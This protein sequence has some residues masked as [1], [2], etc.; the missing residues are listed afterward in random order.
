MER[1]VS[2]AVGSKNV[3][4][5]PVLPE[6]KISRKPLAYWRNKENID[7][8]LLKLQRKYNLNTQED[9]NAISQKHILLNGGRSLLKQ[10]SIYELKCMA[11]P[12]GKLIFNNQLPTGYW[13]NQENI[14]QFLE[15]IKKKYN[16]NTPEDWNSITT[17]HIKSNGGGTL[18]SKYSIYKL[19]CLACPEGKSIF[20]NPKHESGYWEN[21]E[22]IHN[23]F[24]HLKQKYNLDNPE[25]WNSIT[26]KH[27]LSNGGRSLLK[28]YS[29]YELK[30]MACPEGKEIFNNPPGYWENHENILQ[31]LEEIKKKY[32]LNTPEDW[33]S[34]T[35]NHIHSN[36]GRTILKKIFH[37]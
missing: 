4:I 37:V 35:T 16:L 15:E 27:I 21:G 26:Q 34:I 17:S 24:I 36:G 31:F 19:K 22:N 2:K 5:A 20:N 3:K 6:T 32:N 25:K 29:M 10:Y 8:F 18:L 9:W 12:E 13:E 28:K 1:L 33:N 7:N 30:C 23:F 11:Y 14:L